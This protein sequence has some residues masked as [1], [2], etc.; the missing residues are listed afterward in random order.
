MLKKGRRE[1]KEMP[2]SVFDSSLLEV[3]IV[4]RSSDYAEKGTE[5][6]TK[7]EIQRVFLKK[8]LHPA[9]F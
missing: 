5:V 9:A 3:A 8:D 1:G 2:F 7:R 6:R 4:P